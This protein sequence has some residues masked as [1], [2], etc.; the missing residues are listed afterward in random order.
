[1]PFPLVKQSQPE[2]TVHAAPSICTSS[3]IG[4]EIE[5]T[6]QNMLANI[7]RPFHSTRK[8]FLKWVVSAEKQG[9]CAF[10]PYGIPRIPGHS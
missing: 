6:L 2:A 4:L 7:C 10:T 1:M 5:K 9:L 8:Q 3:C